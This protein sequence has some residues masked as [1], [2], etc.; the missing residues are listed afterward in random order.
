MVY[1]KVLSAY[2]KIYQIL[3]ADNNK[4]SPSFYENDVSVF[5]IRGKVKNNSEEL[6]WFLSFLLQFR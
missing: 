4:I 3:M 5:Q 6:I 2:A 1:N